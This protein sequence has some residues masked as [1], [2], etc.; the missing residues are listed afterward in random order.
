MNGREWQERAAFGGKMG[1]VSGVLSPA[2]QMAPVCPRGQLWPI[3]T[4]ITLDFLPHTHTKLL[5][6]SDAF[7]NHE[8]Q[9]KCA[10]Y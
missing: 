6:H 3:C 4:G 1:P 10:L 9:S 7:P 8:D 2:G 5:F